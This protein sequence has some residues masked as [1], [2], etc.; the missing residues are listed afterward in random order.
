MTIRLR[1]TDNVLAIDL[2]KYKSVACVYPPGRGAAVHN[3]DDQPGGTDT[4]DREAP[5]G[6][7]SD[8]GEPAP[9]KG[10][11]KRHGY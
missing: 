10:T 4:I 9:P 3:R 6:S 11:E 8:G 7:D 2:G 1:R 5:A